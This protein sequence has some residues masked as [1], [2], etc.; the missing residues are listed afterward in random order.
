MYKEVTFFG[1]H[2]IGMM[3]PSVAVLCQTE[4]ATGLVALVMP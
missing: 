1:F 4:S 3:K 2:G